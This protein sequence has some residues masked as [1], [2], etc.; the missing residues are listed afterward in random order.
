MITRMDRIRIWEKLPQKDVIQEYVVH[1]LDNGK[2]EG[3]DLDF[4]SPK[5]RITVSNFYEE[6]PADVNRIIEDLQLQG[7]KQFIIELRLGLP[8][9]DDGQES[10]VLKQ[11]Y[12]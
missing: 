8:F 11:V 5:N 7:V 10:V 2:E 12:N 1:D 6:V 3:E 4:F 9:K